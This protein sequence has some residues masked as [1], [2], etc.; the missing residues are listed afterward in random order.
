M[1]FFHLYYAFYINVSIM[2]FLILL[3]DYLNFK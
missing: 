1:F 2:L 3:I